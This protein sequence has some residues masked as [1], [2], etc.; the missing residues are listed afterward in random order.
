MAVFNALISFTTDQPSWDWIKS[1]LKHNDGRTSMQAL[2]N[3]FAGEGNA[4]RNK[5]DANRLKDSLHDK[6]ERAMT[7]EPFLTNCQKMYNIYEKE[8]KPMSEDAKIR[9][10]FKKVQHTGLQ[11]AI[12]ALKVRQ[13]TSED[14]T[15]TQAANHISKAESELPD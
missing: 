9:F 3:H 10:L 12:E 8:D 15:Y 5:A 6:N 2:Q 1:T 7:F 11:P 14:L 4:S 13:S